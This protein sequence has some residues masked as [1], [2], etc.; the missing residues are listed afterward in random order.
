MKQVLA[1][2]SGAVTT[3]V[4]N[5]KGI[6]IW[7]GN[8]PQCTWL[9]MIWSSRLWANLFFVPLVSGY[10]SFYS[11]QDTITESIPLRK[12]TKLERVDLGLRVVADGRWYTFGFENDR[13]LYDWHDDIYVRS[14]LHSSI[15]H[16]FDFA[17]TAHAGPDAIFGLSVN[18][19]PFQL[20]Y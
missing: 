20:S 13:T 19:L 3:F 1:T 5:V 11:L 8:W 10:S 12:I 9:M 6:S 4:T 15:S 7:T 17:H 14:P 16:P 2:L 18:S